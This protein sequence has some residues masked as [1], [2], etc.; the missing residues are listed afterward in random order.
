MW[1]YYFVLV[2]CIS[3]FLGCRLDHRQERPFVVQIE[4][5]KSDPHKKLIYYCDVDSGYCCSTVLD[6]FRDGYEITLKFIIAQELDSMFTIY[7]NYYNQISSCPAHFVSIKNDSIEYI[8]DNEYYVLYGLNNWVYHI[9]LDR[10]VHEYVMRLRFNDCIMEDGYL[11]FR[12]PVVY[13]VD[14]FN[15]KRYEYIYN[16]MDKAIYFPVTDGIWETDPLYYHPEELD[17]RIL[18]FHEKN[19]FLY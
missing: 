13:K 12:L 18:D 2:C 4:Q 10:G 6:H 19:N 3:A 8:C 14:I 5:F 16:W 11:L 9:D 7:L 1:K 15:D 17:Y